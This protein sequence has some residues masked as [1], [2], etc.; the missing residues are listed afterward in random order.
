MKVLLFERGISTSHITI[1]AGYQALGSD[2]ERVS[3]P[4]RRL[5]W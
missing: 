5:E 4:E 3:E 2:F 1:R